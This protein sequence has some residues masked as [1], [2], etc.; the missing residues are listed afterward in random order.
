MIPNLGEESVEI[1]IASWG[2][3]SVTLRFA[4]YLPKDPM[5][6]PSLPSVDVTYSWTGARLDASRPVPAE[7]GNGLSMQLAAAPR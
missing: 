7:S 2:P 5:Y 3:N 4:R 1:S 6:A